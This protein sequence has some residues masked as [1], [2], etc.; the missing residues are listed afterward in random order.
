MHSLLKALGAWALR[1]A[2]GRRAARALERAVTDGRDL[3]ARSDLMMASLMGAVAF[4]KDL[5][6]VHACAHALSAVADLHHGLANGLMLD[7][8]MRFNADAVPARMAELARVA[9]AGEDADALV[10]WLTTLKRW[11][12]LPDSLRAA[13]VQPDQLEAIADVAL[14]DSCL[15]TNPKPCS[16]DDL[17]HLLQAA[18]QPAT[19]R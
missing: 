8:V 2:P 10:G 16:R 12:G 14:H 1:R 7:H 9:G 17:L 19:A 6:A 18:L 4:Q 11:I 13:G 3:A 15:R 5:G